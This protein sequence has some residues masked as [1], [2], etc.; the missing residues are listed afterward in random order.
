MASSH[1]WEDWVS[2]KKNVCVDAW[3]LGA[4]FQSLLS[5]LVGSE[6]HRSRQC[7]SR[8]SGGL[9]RSSTSRACRQRARFLGSECHGPPHCGLQGSEG[10]C[11]KPEVEADAELAPRRLSSIHKVFSRV[12]QPHSASYLHYN[13]GL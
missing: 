13:V 9:P 5:G 7:M 2:W 11:K 12:G 10:W 1:L 4:C 3:N 8:H 6:Q